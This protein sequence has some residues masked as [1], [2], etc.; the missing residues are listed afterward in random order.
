M[1]VNN[2]KIKEMGDPLDTNNAKEL[3]QKM[4]AQLGGEMPAHEDVGGATSNSQEVGASDGGDETKKEPE[5]SVSP[6]KTTTKYKRKPKERKPWRAQTAYEIFCQQERPKLMES[7]PQ[8]CSRE[9]NRRLGTLWASFSR[10]D[11]RQY[12]KEVKKDKQQVADNLKA[13]EW[14]MGRKLKKPVCAYSYYV[15]DKR[16]LTQQENPGMVHV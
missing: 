9:I 13:I 10:K 16:Q 15:K 3:P 11:K 7:Y 8:A 12:N 4:G 1:K 14:K 5:R 6:A 2:E